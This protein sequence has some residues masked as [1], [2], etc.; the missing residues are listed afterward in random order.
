MLLIKSPR[1]LASALKSVAAYTFSDAERNQVFD[2][3]M[4]IVNRTDF[5]RQ[6]IKDDAQ[7]QL[8]C[9]STNRL[10]L[11]YQGQDTDICFLSVNDKGIISSGHIK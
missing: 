9:G 10:Y 7:V 6:L 2:P 4:K 3:V 5:V 8:I 1:K 11:R